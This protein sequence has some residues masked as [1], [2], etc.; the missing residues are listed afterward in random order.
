RCKR[1]RRATDVEAALLGAPR[2]DVEICEP[3][4]CARCLGTG[5]Y[6][7]IGL[8]EPLWVDAELSRLISRGV[9]EAELI[10]HTAGSLTTLRADGFA[11]VLAGITSLEEVL[12][13]TIADT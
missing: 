2:S 12:A 7:R 10:A 8:F 3:A 11:K 1:L 13:T 9:S 5:Y 4:G 6:G